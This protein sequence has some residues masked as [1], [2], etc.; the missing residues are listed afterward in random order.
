MRRKMRPAHCR[1]SSLAHRTASTVPPEAKA[2][3]VIAIA[4]GG[5]H[6]LALIEDGTIVITGKGFFGWMPG[7]IAVMVAAV[8]ALFT[9][10]TGGSG[11]TII[12]LGGLVYPILIEDG[13]SERFSL[14]LLTA[15]GSLGLLF[16]PC[17]PVILY[18]VVAGI[19][20]DQMFRGG[21]LPGILLTAIMGRSDLALDPFPAIRHRGDV[22]S[23]NDRPPPEKREGGGFAPQVDHPGIV[24]EYP[25]GGR[26]AGRSEKSQQTQRQ[27]DQMLLVHPKV[28]RG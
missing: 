20:V 3:D 13:Y 22:R 8:C 15:S 28:L 26:G 27:S 9:T 25:P 14:G 11:V 10:F 4:A 1:S 23:E 24:R 16:P 5:F 6:S 12:A 18:G 7:G 2:G 17:L 21:I 19:G